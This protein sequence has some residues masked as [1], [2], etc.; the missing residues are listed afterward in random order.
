MGRVRNE[1]AVAVRRG[2]ILE[3]A[4][5]LIGERGYY[6][7]TILELGRRCGLSNPGLLHYFPSKQAVLL[8]VLDSLQ[9]AEIDVMEPLAQSAMVELQGDAAKAAVLHILRTIAV[10]AH[11]KPDTC[12]FVA[13]LQSESLD[14]AHPAH[15]WWTRREV[16][17]LDFYTGILRPHVDAPLLVARELL[18]M[19]DG[20][21]LQWLRAGRDFDV[22]AAWD[23]ALARIVPELHMETLHVPTPPPED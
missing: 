8:A 18:A 20:L 1:E 16:A 10:R 21:F 4:I 23:H 12:L 6:G 5:G 13:G 17:V 11:A 22:L 19:M 14:P 7:F 2:Q 15:E 9:L 3:Q